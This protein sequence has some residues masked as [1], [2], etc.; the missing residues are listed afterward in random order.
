MYT[1]NEPGY[2]K[3]DEYGIRTENLV[4]TQEDENGEFLY[5]ETV[6]L[7]PIDLRLID[8]NIMTKSEKAGLNRYHAR[9]YEQVSPLLKDENLKSWFKI[10]CRPMN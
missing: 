2:Y 4:I 7:Y 8:E 10:R 1:S 5:F 6:T 9:V 3:T